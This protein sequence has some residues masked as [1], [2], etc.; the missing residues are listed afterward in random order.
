MRP[1]GYCIVAVVV[2]G[3]IL[4][5]VGILTSSMVIWDGA[6]HQAEFRLHV[7]D[8]QGKPIGGVRI[9]VSSPK[10]RTACGQ[11]VFEYQGEDLI[12]DDEGRF[13]FHHVV[14]GTEFSGHYKEY[15]GYF[16]FG[17]TEAPDYFCHVLKDGVELAR[18]NYKE[19]D[20]AIARDFDDLTGTFWRRPPKLNCP[21]MSEVLVYFYSELPEEL[22]FALW[23]GRVVIH[24]N[25]TATLERLTE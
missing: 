4:I 23:V 5:V 11:P 3:L 25:G 15:F 13:L 18:I 19:L 22:T 16:R 6:F 1:L 24:P 8:E 17:T 2:L 20:G 9:R 12:G 10:G 7:V 14:I 21:E